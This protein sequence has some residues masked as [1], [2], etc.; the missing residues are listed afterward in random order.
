MPASFVLVLVLFLFSFVEVLF[1]FLFASF[2]SFFLFLFLCLV[3]VVL[4]GSWFFL[5]FFT[6]FRR[7]VVSPFECGF[8]SQQIGRGFFR[9]RF[10]FFLLLFL[11]F[12]VEL[13]WFFHVPVVCG[14]WF[15]FFLFFFFVYFGFL[16]EEVFLV[17]E[18][19]GL[20]LGFLI[21][22]GY[23][24]GLCFL[25]SFSS[26]LLSFFCFRSFF[27]LNVDGVLFDDYGFDDS[28]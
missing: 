12:D 24:P 25:F 16:M 26:F 28:F 6:F 13:C 1:L 5:R 14:G 4:V 10:S 21:L 17:W 18:F 7:W 15:F 11:C 23:V 22:A 19:L 2:V 9:V 3:L 8:D 20:F 27:F